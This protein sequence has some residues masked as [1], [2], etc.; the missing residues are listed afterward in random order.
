MTQLFLSYK[1]YEYLCIFI[2]CSLT[3]HMHVQ[4]L[5]TR[6]QWRMYF[7]QRLRLYVV[8]D[9]LE[10]LFFKMILE[11]MIPYRKQTCYGNLTVQFKPKLGCLISTA[12]KIIGFQEQCYLQSLYRKNLYS[13]RH[14][15]FWMTQ[16]TFSIRNESCY[17]QVHDLECYYR[18]KRYK[19][20]FIPTAIK[21]L[22]VNKLL[23]SAGTLVFPLCCALFVWHVCIVY[24]LYLMWC[25]VKDKFPLWGKLKY[26]FFYLYL[27]WE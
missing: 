8:N 4:N 5:C 24:A 21:M 26:I 11:S 17:P 19:N 16:L 10:F 27:I 13:R 3:W 2:V 18:L 1:S 14:T 7:L 20:S 25:V 23:L 15:K 22:I 6:L 9:K 12:F